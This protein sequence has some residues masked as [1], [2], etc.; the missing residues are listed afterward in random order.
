MTP[1]AND[2]AASVNKGCEYDRYFLR[3]K[4]DALASGGHFA[5]PE[6]ERFMSCGIV[7]KLAILATT[8]ALSVCTPSESD[9][10]VAGHFSAQAEIWQEMH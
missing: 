8:A 4:P 2:L 10:A 1:P 3:G 6:R 9:N 5:R 7:I